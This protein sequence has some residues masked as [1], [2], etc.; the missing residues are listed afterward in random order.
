MGPTYLSTLSDTICGS[1]RRP[2]QDGISALG[3]GP[4]MKAPVLAVPS[5][6]FCKIFSHAGRKTT[7]TSYKVSEVSYESRVTQQTE[8]LPFVVAIMGMPGKIL[9]ASP[10]GKTY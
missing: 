6:T 10:K 5:K 7:L 1:F 2:P 9:L 3:L 8:K 4:V